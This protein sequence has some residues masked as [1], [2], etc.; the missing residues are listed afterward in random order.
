MWWYL[1]EFRQS[2]SRRQATIESTRLHTA[3][4]AIIVVAVVV[5]LA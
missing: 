3:Y 5:A 4:N 1:R 2:G